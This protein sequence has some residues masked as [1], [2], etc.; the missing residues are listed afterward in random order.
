MKWY[1]LAVYGMYV[2]PIYRYRSNPHWTERE[3]FALGLPFGCFEI[4]WFS[5]ELVHF[6]L[7]TKLII[8]YPFKGFLNTFT[9]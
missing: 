3:N 5:V 7:I 2:V 6:C 4:F 9:E 8:D 1:F